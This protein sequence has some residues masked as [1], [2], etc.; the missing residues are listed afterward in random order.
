[1]IQPVIE[2]LRMFW[3][4]STR[5]EKVFMISILGVLIFELIF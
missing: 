1:M 5:I 2:A 4:L 3:S